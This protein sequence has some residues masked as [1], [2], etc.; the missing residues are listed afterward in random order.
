M[1]YDY[2]MKRYKIY[3]L[4][5]ALLTTFLICEIKYDN[6]V[7]FDNVSINTLDN[8]SNKYSDGLI[9]LAN[10]NEEIP[11][12]R[13]NYEVVEFESLEE[14]EIIVEADTEKPVI[15][16]KKTIYSTVGKKVNLL[17]KVT[18]TDNSGEEL[19][20]KVEGEYDINTIGTYKLKYVAV[21]S[22]NN[23]TEES[24]KLVV[25]EPAPVIETQAV[26]APQVP[27]VVGTMRE[28]MVSIAKSQVG[29]VNGN[30]YWSWYGFKGRVEWCATFV[31]WTANQAGALNTYIPKFAGVG[32]GYSYFSKRGQIRGKS[33]VP[34][35]GDLIFFDWGNRGRAGH[36]GIVEKVE[37]GRVY[38]I[39]GNTN[40][41]KVENRSY[42]LNHKNIHSYAVPSYQ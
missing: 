19:Q 13:I 11:V 9:A 37:G 7:S 39:E 16:F 10:K 14:P 38:V 12:K 18:V 5:V 30:P 33:Y 6:K 1:D 17:K 36:V 25:Q 41:N 8:I 26:E 32:T 29:V 4:I 21:D 23:R 3:V 40:N 28:K 31:S 15:K 2:F 20:V 42:P 34:S 27:V 22:S 24:F 35:A